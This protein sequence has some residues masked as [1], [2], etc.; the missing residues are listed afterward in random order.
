[1][2]YING[3][4]DGQDVSVSVGNNHPEDILIHIFLDN[5]HQGVKYSNQISIHQA[6]L[7]I[8]ENIY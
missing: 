5:F 4:Q 2:N 6:E 7:K 3:F 1:M 8:E